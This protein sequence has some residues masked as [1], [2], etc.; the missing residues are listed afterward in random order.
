MMFIYR[1]SIIPSGTNTGYRIIIALI[2]LLPSKL[3]Q[4]APNALKANGYFLS[5]M[6]TAGIM[7]TRLP[8]IGMERPKRFPYLVACFPPLL[9]ISVSNYVKAFTFFHFIHTDRQL[10]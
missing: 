8:S 7:P 1:C 2:F 4:E 6:F 10:Y 9:I 3:N 5:L